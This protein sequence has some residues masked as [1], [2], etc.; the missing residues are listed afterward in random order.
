VA[1]RRFFVDRI[2]GDR[3]ELTGGDA[4]HLTRVLRAETG[5]RYEISDNRRAYLAE[6]SEAAPKRVAFHIIEALPAEPPAPR[7]T[8]YAALIKFDRFEWLVEKATELGAARIVPVNA[9]RSEKGL[10]EAGGRRVERWRKIARESSQQARRVSLPEIAVPEPFAAAVK[11]P[12]LYRYVLEEQ[13][14]AEPLWRALPQPADRAA[15]DAIA[16]LVGPEG[17]WT[18]TERAGAR[19]AG[20]RAIS[21]AGH[22]L[23]A[24]TAALAGLAVIG[25][26]WS[27]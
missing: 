1:R 13:P 15:E 26:A 16:L 24:E 6:I 25:A 23:R 14:G 17:G 21:I 11:D 18:D 19:A 9:G 10:A 5:Q 27:A 7:V 4:A 3:A 8:L 2:D 12:S 22:I 20:W